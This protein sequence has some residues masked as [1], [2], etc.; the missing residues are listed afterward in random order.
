MGEDLTTGSGSGSRKDIHSDEQGMRSRQWAKSQVASPWTSN[1]AEAAY[2]TPS[3]SASEEDSSM[4]PTN[5]PPQ[6][7]P[8]LLRRN[9][10]QDSYDDS[11]PG[12]PE[13][14]PAEMV[15]SGPS[16][17]AGESQ[18]NSGPSSTRKAKNTYIVAS[19][20]A[21]LRRLLKRELERVSQ[22]QHLPTAY[23]P[24]KQQIHT[25]IYI[26]LSMIMTIRTR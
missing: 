22:Y 2:D 23:R 16:H 12:T 4:K 13:I 10:S 20:D 19:D 6:T 17:D 25:H 7:V 11:S 24:R 14:I 1:T 26:Y 5:K 8:V 9:I 18:R 15:I 3:D 21:E